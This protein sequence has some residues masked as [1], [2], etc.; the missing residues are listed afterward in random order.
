MQQGRGRQDRKVAQAH[1]HAQQRQESQQQGEEHPAVLRRPSEDADDGSQCKEQ[2]PQRQ[3]VTGH[4]GD[5]GGG[6]QMPAPFDDAGHQG[7]NR[8]A[9][10]VRQQVEQEHQSDAQPGEEARQHPGI[11]ER[12]APFL[13]LKIPLG[14]QANPGRQQ[15]GAQD[16]QPEGPGEQGRQAVGEMVVN[17]QGVGRQG[18]PPA[19]RPARPQSGED[20]RRDRHLVPPRPGQQEEE[21]P[22]QQR[23]KQGQT[24]RPPPVQQ[25]LPGPDRLAAV[26][27]EE[28]QGSEEEDPGE[29]S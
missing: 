12:R 10:P 15:A 29:Q 3:H 20:H 26:E 25:P 11:G 14:P 5:A 21:D 9:S 16:Q 24:V 13:G 7:E 8:H 6:V 4:Q 18:R 28:Q 2:R 17:S 19:H 27:I 23:Q 1:Q 22:A